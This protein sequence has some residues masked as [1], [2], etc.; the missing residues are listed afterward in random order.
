M[1]CRKAGVIMIRISQTANE[2][3]RKYGGNVVLYVDKVGCGGG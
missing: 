3:I 1:I 2:Y